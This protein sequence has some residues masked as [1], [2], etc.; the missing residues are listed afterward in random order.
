MIKLDHNHNVLA[1]FEFSALRR[2]TDVY[3]SSIKC[4]DFTSETEWAI[5]DCKGRRLPDRERLWWGAMAEGELKILSLPEGWT[6]HILP[7]QGLITEALCQMR[8]ESEFNA[9][10][11]NRMSYTPSCSYYQRDILSRKIIEWAQGL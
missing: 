7:T 4:T 9:M 3:V 8:I 11:S 6:I 1:Q 2:D 5:F 10:F